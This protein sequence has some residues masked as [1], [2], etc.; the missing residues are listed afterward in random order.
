MPSMSENKVGAGSA[1]ADAIAVL[2]VAL[3]TTGQAISMATLIFAGPLDAA[4][5][6]A[7]ASFCVAGGVL[8]I[9]VAL[10][11]RIVPSPTT[12]QDAPAIVLVAV[13]ASVAAGG[14]EVGVVDVFAMLAVTSLIT[15]IVMWLVGRLRLGGLVRYMPATVIGAFMAGTGWLLVKGGLD[16]MVGFGVGLDDLADLF[17]GDMLKFWIPGFV[18]SAVT[19]AVGRSD[20]LPPAALGGTVLICTLGFYVVVSLVSSI[21]A[22]E[23]A[24]W[25]IGHSPRERAQASSHRPNS[26][27]PDGDGSLVSSLV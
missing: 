6:R 5:P 2:A 19:T 3:S 16:V 13:A 21:G 8:S 9:Y 12:I 26:L 4:L 24:G 11:S 10:R 7:V 14:G 18:I 22:V 27:T 25:L 17:T 20:R 1:V 15:G 23:D